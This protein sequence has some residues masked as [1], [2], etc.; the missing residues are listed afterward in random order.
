MCWYTLSGKVL[1]ECTGESAIDDILS[2]YFESQRKA[3]TS[4]DRE[5]DIRIYLSY[6]LESLQDFC[7]HVSY[8]IKSSR[9]FQ[10]HLKQTEVKIDI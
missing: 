5:G 4:K 1:N 6:L 10:T 9:K 7:L 3:H 2:R 8:K